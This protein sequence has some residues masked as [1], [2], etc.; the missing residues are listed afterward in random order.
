MTIPN[1]KIRG[2]FGLKTKMRSIQGRLAKA[3]GKPTAG[4]RTD[5]K[6]AGKNVIFLHNPKTGGSSLEK[7][8]GVKRLSH[9]LASDRLSEPQWLRSY[10]VAAVRNP[11]ER[12]LS[13]YYSHILRPEVN[14]FS[15]EYGMEIKNISPF[16]YLE[17]LADNPQYGGHQTRWTDYPSVEKP[18]ADLIL[19]FEEIADWGRQLTNAGIDIGQRKLRHLNPSQRQGSDHL[20]VL[21][22]SENE[23]ARLETTVKNYFETDCQ[24]FGY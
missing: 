18:S 1:R 5:F 2:P 13:G 19:R 14:G 22:L 15:K 20:K 6:R 12:F 16:D 8:L 24:R 3:H 10:S 7:L 4:M 23:F 17:L 21:K 9:S 11:F